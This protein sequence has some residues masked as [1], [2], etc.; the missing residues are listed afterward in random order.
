MAP[1]RPVN[2]PLDKG[3]DLEAEIFQEVL[4]TEDA[5]IGIKSFLEK[6]PG[7]AD[8]VGR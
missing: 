2:L 8:F 7:K 1:G 5:A 6:G 4:R 3:L